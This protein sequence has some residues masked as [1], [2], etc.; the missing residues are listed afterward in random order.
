[1]KVIS[2]V[3]SVASFVLVV[4]ED[5]CIKNKDIQAGFILQKSGG[6]ARVSYFRLVCL[7]FS[8]VIIVVLE[9]SDICIFFFSVLTISVVVACMFAE[10]V[11]GD[12][13]SS[14]YDH[15]SSKERKYPII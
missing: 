11:A 12:D 10:A 8:T 4:T 3:S 7:S 14:A 13:L 15:D 2:V 5:S 6:L 1:M 9:G